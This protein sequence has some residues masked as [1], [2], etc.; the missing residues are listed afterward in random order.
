VVK[1]TKK[2][3]QDAV[4]QAQEQKQEPKH[5]TGKEAQKDPK[6]KQIEELT[7]L[8]K[9]VQADFENFK[10][11]TEKEKKEFSDYAC[12]DFIK[13]FLPLMD[14]FELALKNKTSSE[15][16]VKGI[17]LIYAQFASLL[18]SFGV[19]RI[20]ANGKKFDPCLHEV[21]L[22]EESDKEE[23]KILEELQPGYIMKNCVLRHSKVKIAK[24]GNKQKNTS[25]QNTQA[26]K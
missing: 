2:E 9:R 20:E 4:K 23:G 16:F 13:S 18:D 19:R 5:E 11:R 8:V 10:K 14:S 3:I 22:V 12:A 1:I 25:Q 26:G 24:N 6:E 21:L 7:F 15:D 17:E